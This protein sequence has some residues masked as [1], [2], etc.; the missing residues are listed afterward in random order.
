[1]TKLEI[2]FK[3]VGGQILI[4]F[5]SE[6]L[7]IVI[8]KINQTGSFVLISGN[9][10]RGKGCRKRSV[11]SLKHAQNPS[12]TFDQLIDQLREVCNN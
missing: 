9:N 8:E 7:N 6:L 3:E 1:M 10:V 12:V 4:D 2:N 5:P 11:I